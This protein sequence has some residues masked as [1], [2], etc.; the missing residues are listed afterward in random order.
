MTTTL[1]NFTVIKKLGEGTYSTV[2]HVLRRDDQCEYALKKVKMQGLTEKERENAVNEVRI[3]A[4]IRGSNKNI[5]QYKEAF[6]DAP[7][8]SLW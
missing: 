1:D 3:L 5:I 8:D 7:S 2:Y 4:S 6:V